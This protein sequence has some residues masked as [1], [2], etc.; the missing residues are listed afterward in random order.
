MR[1][2]RGLHRVGRDA[3]RGCLGGARI[4]S[5]DKSF[6][7]PRDVLQRERADGLEG[8]V[9]TVA[10]MVAH[11]PRD[12]DAARRALRLQPRGDVHA[13]AVKIRTMR[14]HVADVDANAEA[15]APVRLLIGIVYRH[16][17]L[18]L[19]RAAYRAVDAVERDEQ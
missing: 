5:Q 11:G 2:L 12:A 13:V 18:H 3:G 1:W 9:E 10:H 16:L 15:N 17:M 7:R 19:G 6:H 8:Q 14:N 4:D